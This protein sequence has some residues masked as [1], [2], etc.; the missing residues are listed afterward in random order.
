MKWRAGRE[1]FC[2]RSLRPIAAEDRGV[3]R[4]AVH[5]VDRVLPLVADYRQWTLSFPRWLRLRLLRDKALVS[6]V[7]AIVAQRRASEHAFVM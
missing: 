1:R 5:L 2:E 4:F 6:E 7:L 3:R